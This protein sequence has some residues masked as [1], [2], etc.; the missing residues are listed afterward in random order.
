MNVLNLNVYWTVPTTESYVRVI[1][2]GLGFWDDFT[3]SQDQNI[4]DPILLLPPT[5]DKQCARPQSQMEKI[6]VKE[7]CMIWKVNEMVTIWAWNFV[8]STS[9]KNH[10]HFISLPTQRHAALSLVLSYVMHAKFKCSIKTSVM[11][12]WDVI[13]TLKKSHTNT[14]TR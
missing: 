12:C 9:K 4:K 6:K 10:R 11:L 8:S 1:E 13:E 3:H 5:L 7:F 2:A 14:T